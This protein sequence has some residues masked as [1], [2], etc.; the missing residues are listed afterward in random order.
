MQIVNQFKEDL[1]NKTQIQYH[2]A[3]Y[4]GDHYNGIK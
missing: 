2:N 3:R 4:I 1:K